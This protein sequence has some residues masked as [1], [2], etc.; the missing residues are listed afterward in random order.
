MS[1]VR[2]YELA[3][4]LN[5]TSK[6]LMEKLSEIK[7]NVKNHMSLLTD[8]ELNSLY[9][10]IGII[11]HEAKSEDKD[12]IENKKPKVKEVITKE[13]EIEIRKKRKTPRIIRK[14]EIIINT[15]NSSN[16]YGTYKEA[17]KSANKYSGSS[18]KGNRLQDR[19]RDYVKSDNSSSGLR[20]GFIRDVGMPIQ[21]K[22]NKPITFKKEKYII[23]NVKKP[24]VHKKDIIGN[25]NII[26]E[27]QKSK[28]IIDNKNIIKKDIEQKIITKKVDGNIEKRETKT[29]ISKDIKKTTNFTSNLKDGTKKTN[30]FVKK[31]NISSQKSTYGTRSSNTRTGPIVQ[32]PTYGT[33]STNIGTRST[34]VGTRSTNAGTRSTYNTS[35]NSYST[36]T[37]NKRTVSKPERE[38]K[39]VKPEGKDIQRSERRNN[40][41]KDKYKINLTK[42]KKRENIKNV[43]TTRNKRIAPAAFIL[44]EKKGINEVLSEEF[45]LNE[46]YSDSPRVRRRRKKVVIKKVIPKPILLSITIGEAI[47]VKELAEVLK[48]TSTEVIKKLITMGVMVT[49]NQEI[50]F[51]T[52]TI[53]ADEFN[54]KTE[55][56]II[57][58]EEDI[59][60]D[61]KEDDKEEDLKPRPPV[62]VVMG[63]VD[64]GKTLLLDTI[65]KT[66]VISGEAGGITQHIGAYTVHIHN[67]DITFLDTPGHEAFTAMRARG[68][69]VTDIAVLVIAAD[70]GIMPQTVEAINHAKAAGVTIIVA[71]NKIDKVGA[72]IDKV[73]QGL[74]EHGLVTEEWGGDTICVPISALKGE[75]IDGLLEM[76]LL[77]TDMLDLKANPSRQVKGTVIESRLDVGR[78]PIAT[79]LVQRGT[80]KIGD[81]IITGTTFG[82]VRVMLDDKGEQILEAGPSIPVE[83]TG[84]TEAPK[85]GDFFYVIKDEK[86][87]KQLIDK[88]K[89]IQ[90]EN[91][92]ASTSKISLEDLYDRIKQ[93]D[94]KELN[95]IV[96][97]DVQG[98]VEAVRQSIQKLSNDEVKIII[99]HGGVGAVTESDVKLAEV[100]NAIIIGFN[101][102]PT[103]NVLEAVANAGVDMRLYTIIYN[104][105]DDIKD[106]M[107]G[108]LDPTFKEA[109]QGHTEI[110]QIFKASG[111]G[112]IGGSFVLDGKI[113]RNSNIRIVRN[114]SVI[115]EGKLASLKRFKD[116]VKEVEQGYECGISIEKYND[117]K[118]KDIIESFIMEEV[119]RD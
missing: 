56:V 14:T 100:A 62:V 70:D 112:T 58:N 4:E 116:D 52:A 109:V 41:S 81:S 88:R 2:V 72:N 113:T 77:S 20:A 26:I 50:D 66:N 44:N 36:S 1:K 49:L 97:A 16:G 54:I 25:E 65:R 7:I 87:A 15:N 57:I 102:R 3:K 73:K 105:I 117:I 91:E 18:Y 114:G 96:K 110:R 101:I 79:L 76:I 21:K 85:S 9:K 119:E 84:L 83:V 106:A 63:H 42:D 11:I 29:L 5:T 107:K 51:D 99:I 30:G 94:I 61:D 38:T 31:S 103:A 6:R 45:I 60:F 35:E 95:I 86:V 34:N 32:R 10:H 24:I 27:T 12:L 46:F 111:I 43:G 115:H 48:K 47:T 69:Q 19:K 23:D 37:H 53:I 67:R 104:A 108:L 89:T 13:K 90:R 55:K 118:E 98:S 78:G 40:Y 17:N 71:I 64:H 8:E 28:N 59:L 68:A 39:L 93:G 22:F 82:R 74:T 92:L 33:R 75:N 80:L